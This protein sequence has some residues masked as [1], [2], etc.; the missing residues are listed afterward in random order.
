MEKTVKILFVYPEHGRR[1]YFPTAIGYLAT[2]ILEA[3]PEAEIEVVDFNID[4]NYL[5]LMDESF[6]YIF[7]SGL[8]AHFRSIEEIIDFTK[9]VNKKSEVVLGGIVVTGIFVGCRGSGS[10][11]LEYREEACP[12]LKQPKAIS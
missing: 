4:K 3:Q 12:A 2:A 6:D 5:K 10:P 11:V 9:E 7:V 8:S 1:P